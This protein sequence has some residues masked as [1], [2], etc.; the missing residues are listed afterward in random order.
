[1]PSRFQPSPLSETTYHSYFDGSDSEFESDIGDEYQDIPSRPTS[2]L[3]FFSNSSEDL[4]SEDPPALE[5]DIACRQFDGL[6]WTC[7]ALKRMGASSTV[8][9]E[10]LPRSKFSSPFDDFSAD[11]VGLSSSED[12][13]SDIEQDRLFERSEPLELAFP[14]PLLPPPTTSRR[15]FSCLPSP[16]SPSPVH[17]PTPSPS[18]HD[19]EQHGYSRHGLHHLKWFW[20][21]RE[22]E[23]IDAAYDGVPQIHGSIPQPVPLPPMSVHPRRGDISAL[24]D[25]FCVHMDRYFVAIPM[26]TMAKALWMFDMHMAGE[27]KARLKRPAEEEDELEELEDD[28]TISIGGSSS[29]DDSEVTLVGSDGEDGEYVE[30]DLNEERSAANIIPVKTKKAGRRR[31]VYVTPTAVPV[32]FAHRLPWETSWYKR[33]ELLLELTRLDREHR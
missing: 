2:R 23:W 14:T 29:G 28:L 17:C 6:K 5:S 4:A 10:L 31:K 24:R 12:S 25:P 32:S 7:A 11:D 13:D 33:T 8:G 16:L 15:K 27:V 3:G 18:R 20:A 22:E 1:M 30:V 26:W 9:E 21:L 19:Y